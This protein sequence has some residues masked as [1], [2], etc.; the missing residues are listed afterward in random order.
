MFSIDEIESI[1]DSDIIYQA[2]TTNKSPDPTTEQISMKRF[3][4]YTT[5]GCMFFIEALVTIILI[6]RVRSPWIMI[7][8]ISIPVVL[9]IF[10]LLRTKLSAL[11]IECLRKIL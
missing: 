9:G 6:Y 7:V 4:W 5:V 3:L 10:F 11:Q 1:D 8:P 2:V